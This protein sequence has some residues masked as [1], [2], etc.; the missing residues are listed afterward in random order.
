MSDV[1]VDSIC[2]ISYRATNEMEQE[3]VA[4]ILNLRLETELEAERNRGIEVEENL[5]AAACRAQAWEEECDRF[6]LFG[7]GAQGLGSR[8]QI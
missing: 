8:F 7:S 1:L 2:Y 6:T 4:D 3:A 5:T